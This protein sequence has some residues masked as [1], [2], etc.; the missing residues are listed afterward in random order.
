MLIVG[1]SYLILS[2]REISTTQHL[3]RCW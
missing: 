3:K 2:L 1:F